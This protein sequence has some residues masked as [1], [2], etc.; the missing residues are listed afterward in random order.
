MTKKDYIKFASMLAI[1]RPGRRSTGYWED[2]ISRIAN[3]FADDNP[4]FDRERFIAACHK[5]V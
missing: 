4:S 3:I 2:L 5:E 1:K